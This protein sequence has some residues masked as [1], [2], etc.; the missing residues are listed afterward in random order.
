MRTRGPLA[1]KGLWLSG[2]TLA[3]LVCLIRAAEPKVEVRPWGD[4]RT[5]MWVGDSVWQHREKF[6]LFVRRMREMGIN[7]GMV[8]GDGD[9]QPWIDNQF[10]YYVENLVNRGLCMKFNSKVTDW[11][12][13]VTEWAKSGRPE[14]SLVRDYC[15]DDPQWLSWAKSTTAKVVKQ[16]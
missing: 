15:I 8:Y 3:T 4:Y 1:S 7:T 16:N 5:I 13:F 6:S 9:P 12:K 11:D 10:P 2:L 14:S